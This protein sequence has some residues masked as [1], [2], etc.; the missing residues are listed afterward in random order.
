MLSGPTLE[1]AYKRGYDDGL[2]AG[3]V[4]VIQALGLLAWQNGGTL[5]IND[6]DVR[7]MPP[8][9]ELREYRNIESEVTIY[10]TEMRPTARR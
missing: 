5:Q 8:G 10:R 6:R 9:L 7:D 4:K 3:R 1:E 2:G